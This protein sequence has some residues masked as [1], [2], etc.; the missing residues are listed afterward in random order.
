MKALQLHEIQFAKRAVACWISEF[1]YCDTSHTR[2][3]MEKSREPHSVSLKGGEVFPKCLS[4]K[5]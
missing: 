4:S 1:E 2:I 3:E 5:C